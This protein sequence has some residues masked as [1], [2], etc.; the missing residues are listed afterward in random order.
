[1]EQVV[2]LALLL[3]APQ[4]ASGQ[5]Q[6]IRKALAACGSLGI[7]TARLDC[8][9]R[10]ANAVTQIPFKSPN[11]PVS[12][13]N[14]SA[15]DVPTISPSEAARHIGEEVVVE[16]VI[17]DVGYSARTDTTFLNMGGKYPN[18]AFTAVIFKSSKA[19]FPEVQ[20][21]EGKKVRIRGVVKEYRGKPEIVL[22]R[23]EQ[24]EVVR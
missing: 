6:E 5:E 14:E 12:N 3:S 4:T 22:A 9:E 15:R 11:P 13:A 20:S 1:M 16:G 8:F 23:R 7:E 21:W 18:H 10:L 17:S 24:V 2:L 19:L